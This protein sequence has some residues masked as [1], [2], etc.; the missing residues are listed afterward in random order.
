MQ[1]N[2]SSSTHED[3][4]EDVLRAFTQGA[5]QRLGQLSVDEVVNAVR[6]FRQRQ[7]SRDQEPRVSGSAIDAYLKGSVFGSFSQEQVESWALW[8]LAQMPR[9]Q[10]AALLE[11]AAK[12]ANG[13]IRMLMYQLVKYFAG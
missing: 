6:S 12:V 7:N 9:A 3:A 11:A 5:A 13:D 4:L 8:R 1:S 2:K 10:G